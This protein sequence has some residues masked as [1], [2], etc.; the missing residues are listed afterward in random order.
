[1]E[2]EPKQIREE[3]KERQ[4]RTQAL[5]IAE[6]L[7][8][9]V[10]VG[11][12]FYDRPA[13]LAYL[14]NHFPPF[15]SSPFS[16]EVRGLGYGVLV[17]SRDPSAT[18]TLVVDN[19]GVR[20]DLIAIEDVRVNVNLS[21]AVSEVLLEQGWRQA[22]IGLVGEDL[23]P[24]SLFRDWQEAVPGITWVGADRVLDRQ[25]RLKSPLEQEL[26]RRA[27]AVAD[28]VH[29]SALPL[30]E[31]GKTERYICA[32]GIAAAMQAGADFVRYFRVHSG[33]WSAWGSRWP[34]ATDRILEE[35]DLV[36][37]DII[38]AVNGY[39]FDVSRTCCAGE[40]A[41]RELR[42]LE[43]AADATAAMVAA[44]RP[45]VAVDA[46]IAVAQRVVDAAGFGAYLSPQCGHGIGLDTME[47]P[48]LRS[49]VRDL[50]ETG[51][52]L[53][54]EPSI[55][56]PRWGGAC[57]EEEVIVTEDGCEVITHAPARPWHLS[58]GVGPSP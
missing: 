23:L 25:R 22:I 54:L 36:T 3:C 8:G 49:G 11:H 47:L 17:L 32:V 28:A 30:V 7:D 46:L 12:S 29:A 38:G 9:L 19:P 48:Y 20:R 10:V 35:S 44:V 33:E 26:L 1:V 45:G 6:G 39:Q 18:P 53:C 51:M 40:P 50:L 24:V 16:D 5:L 14:T 52:V 31:P 41:A 42:L 15:P 37:L 56:I 34:Q 55:Y 27:A 13:N 57:V 58:T 21:Q 4:E 43:A 2:I